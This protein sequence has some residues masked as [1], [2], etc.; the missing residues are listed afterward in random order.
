MVLNKIPFQ[1]DKFMICI[2]QGVTFAPVDAM[3][4]NGFE[5]SSVVNPTP[6]N[7]ERDAA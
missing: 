1:P 7:I 3:P 5:K 2:L 4:I 6:R